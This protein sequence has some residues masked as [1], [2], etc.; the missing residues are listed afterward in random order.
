MCTFQSLHYKL[1]AAMPRAM[2]PWEA[3]LRTGGPE[4]LLRP[5]ATALVTE[6]FPPRVVCCF[7]GA[8]SQTTS[9][10]RCTQGPLGWTLCPDATAMGGLAVLVQVFAFLTFGPLADYGSG[11]KHVS[12]VIL[13][14]PFQSSLHLA[15]SPQG[16]AN[17]CL[18]DVGGRYTSGM[19]SLCWAGPPHECSC[20]EAGPSWLQMLMA[21]TLIGASMCI[22]TLMLE[23]VSFW[24]L[25][26]VYLVLASL[27]FGLACICFNR[28]GC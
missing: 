10:L 8:V 16:S 1:N 9:S 24:W 17:P 23:A 4:N 6:G 20:A 26:G 15:C 18:R 12:N 13:A 14:S 21:G 7:C 2:Y 22:L 11:R 5:S 27:G 3:E 25:A 19:N 28:W